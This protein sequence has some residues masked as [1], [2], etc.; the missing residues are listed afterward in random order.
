M[1]YTNGV[2]YQAIPYDFRFSVLASDAPKHIAR[3]IQELHRNTGKKVVIF[4]HSLGN[5]HI[6]K[7]LASLNQTFKN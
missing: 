3:S 6:L 1:G 2:N 7:A 4:G 5:I